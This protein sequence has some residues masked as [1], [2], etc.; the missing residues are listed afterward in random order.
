MSAEEPAETPETA[1]APT[2]TPGRLL[3]V[4]RPA[5]TPH[6]VVMFNG[7]GNRAFAAPDLPFE[8][9]LEGL[10]KLSEMDAHAI[11]YVEDN[12]S[13]LLEHQEAILDTLTAYIVEHRIDQ[14]KLIGASAGGYA[15]LR[16]GLLL[17]QRLAQLEQ[18]VAVISF[19]I[20]PQT[21]FRPQLIKA[22]SDE[23]L[24][25]RWRKGRLG[26][27]PILLPAPYYHAYCDQLIEISELYATLT[28]VNYGAAVF[29][30]RINPIERVFSGDLT[31]AEIFVP[32]PQNLNLDH[33]GGCAAIWQGNAFWETFDSVLPFAT[34]VPREIELQRLV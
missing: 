31:P 24:L 19:P 29:F 28:P 30:D 9:H 3:G 32:M 21:G 10:G 34:I 16:I 25:S 13:W 14:V 18:S 17:D 33:A 2:F 27:N 7:Y 8:T 15:A 23:I 22:V 26:S 5:E 11:W 1:P 6:L 12:T 4:A 20:N